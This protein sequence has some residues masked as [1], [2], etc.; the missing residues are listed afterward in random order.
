MGQVQRERR[1]G[2]RRGLIG[3]RL[4]PLG[5]VSLGVVRRRTEVIAFI[6]HRRLPLRGADQVIGVL[7]DPF[8][9]KSGLVG[10]T[11]STVAFGLKSICLAA[12]VK[13]TA[14]FEVARA[15]EDVGV[16]VLELRD[17]AGYV[18]DVLRVGR[19]AEHLHAVFRRP[20]LRSLGHAGGEEGV[21]VGDDHGPGPHAGEGLK[22]GL[23]VVAGG[24]QHGEQV[25]V[26][27][28][29][30]RFGCPRPLNHDHPARVGYLDGALGE[31]GTVRAQQEVDFILVDEPLDEIGGSVRVAGVVV[32]D[33]LDPVAVVAHLDTAVLAVDPFFPEDIA[34]PCVL[35]FLGVPARLADG[36][37]DRDDLFLII[38][39]SRPPARV[40]PLAAVRDTERL[41]S[42]F[43]H[44]QRDVWGSNQGSIPTLR[45]LVHS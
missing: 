12:P 17:D 15:H 44:N 26:L 27:L 36:G 18:G 30:E 21:R 32:H 45:P 20:A 41:G 42:F 28:P 25:L 34:T 11:V 13:R 1:G 22:R 24:S 40:T 38:L 7:A 4:S 31:G 6:A 3:G 37:P 19:D 5:R 14:S 35:A 39:P 2:G 43:L 29:E 8:R 33:Q 9:L 10:P 16:Q 23:R